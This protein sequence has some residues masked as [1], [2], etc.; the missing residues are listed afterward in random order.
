MSEA[1]LELIAEKNAEIVRLL[2]ALRTDGETMLK[3]H[4]LLSEKDAEI[5]QLKAALKAL[6]DHADTTVLT[7]WRDPE[8]FQNAR[9]VVEKLK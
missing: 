5:A 4:M 8:V 6:L 2:T 3:W 7:G 1:E 9:R